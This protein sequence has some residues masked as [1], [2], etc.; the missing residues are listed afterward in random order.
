[1]RSI[2]NGCQS[3]KV[4]KTETRSKNEN[5]KDQQSRR[6]RVETSGGEGGENHEAQNHEAQNHEAQNHE[7]QNHEAQNHEAKEKE[8]QITINIYNNTDNMQ[9]TTEKIKNIA[10]IAAL[11]VAGIVV[12]KKLKQW[13]LIGKGNKKAN[14]SELY[15][16]LEDDTAAEVQGRATITKTEAVK[17][18]SQIK[19]AWGV[20]NDDEEAIYTVFNRVRNL[21][22]ILLIIDAY[23]IYRPNAFV[24]GADLVTDLR[25][26]LGKNELKKINDIISSKGINYQF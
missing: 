21:A 16:L 17:Y 9:L 8:L 4:T 5:C 1:M 25:K 26:R 12:A 18:A 20:L 19:N 24:T 15:Q 23:G 13:G 14:E 6:G 3:C 10:L 11:V 7:A 2:L 22:D